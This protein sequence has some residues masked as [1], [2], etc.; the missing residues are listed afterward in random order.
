[1]FSLLRVSSFI[2]RYS[3]FAVKV[4]KGLKSQWK[5]EY[6]EIP[7]LYLEI[8]VERVKLNPDLTNLHFLMT[9][10]VK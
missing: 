7:Q 8:K 4:L 9:L 6:I 3:H 10:K 2:D 5:S 1:M